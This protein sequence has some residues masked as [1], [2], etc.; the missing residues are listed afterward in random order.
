MERVRVVHVQL[1]V[2][3]DN[4]VQREVRVVVIVQV[5]Q[6]ILLL[7]VMQLVIV[8]IGHVIL[9]TL[10]IQLLVFSI[11]V[12]HRERARKLI[13]DEHVHHMIDVVEQK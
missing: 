5:N 4:I 7:Q 9:V 11:A 10:R 8:V 12:Q 3:H 13:I 1:R 6:R 2:L